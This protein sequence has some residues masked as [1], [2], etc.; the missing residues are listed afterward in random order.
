MKIE[1]IK[2]SNL[3]LNYPSYFNQKKD[4]K[5]KETKDKNISFQSLLDN[6]I[7]KLRH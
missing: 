2:K 5:E 4:M 1:K 3:N 6:E 7:E